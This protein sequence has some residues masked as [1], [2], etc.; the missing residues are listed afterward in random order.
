MKGITSFKHKE[1]LEYQIKKHSTSK[2]KRYTIMRKSLRNHDVALIRKFFSKIKSV[3]CMGC[4]DD[5]E[6]QTF[7]KAGFDAI[8]FDI[9][10]ETR[11]IKKIDAHKMNEYFD[12][13]DLIY[14]SHAL[15]HMYDVDK[16]MKHVKSIAKNVVIILPVSSNVESSLS[17]PTIFEIMKIKNRIIGPQR[18]LYKI[19]SDFDSL[20]PFDILYTEYRK[21]RGSEELCIYLEL[22]K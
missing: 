3:I 17:H 5:S 9:N 11:L 12:A 1:V 20:E 15:E 22:K 6:V 2:R 19:R 7:I 13:V 8:G 4:R 14:A 18:L 16:V 21:W 10:C